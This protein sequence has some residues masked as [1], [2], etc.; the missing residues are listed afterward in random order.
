MS[1]KKALV[2]LAV[3]VLA[4]LVVSVF[5][6]YGKFTDAAKQI[7][8]LK[9]QQTATEEAMTGLTDELAAAQEAQK[10]AEDAAAAAQE[11]QK[12]AEDAAAAAQEAQK[13]AEDKAAKAQEAQKIAEDETAKAVKAQK[14]A[15]DGL[16][17]LQKTSGE[18]IAAAQEAQ[19]NAEDELVKAQKAQKTAEDE[20]AKAQKAVKEDEEQILQLEERIRE[21]ENPQAGEAEERRFTGKNE[22]ISLVVPDGANASDNGT[23]TIQ[24]IFADGGLVVLRRPLFE[25]G[26]AENE[27]TVKWADV[28]TEALNQLLA[29]V[30]VDAADAQA[31]Q[32]T[33]EGKRFTGKSVKLS[34][35]A[36]EGAGANDPGNGMILVIFAN[37]GLVVFSN[38]EDEN[39][40]M[41]KWADV[42]A[43]VLNQLLATVQVNA[44]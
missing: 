8:D 27:M 31:V 3:I 21:L 6:Y 36:P 13:E 35:I 29:T 2:C 10:T 9:N 12:T 43:D 18:E 23:G 17:K 20:L 14:A 25:G 1:K 30:R 32:K 16:A 41:M 4:A 5:V 44:D 22:G 24:V 39:E 42:E 11:A 7:V 37:G 26:D 33:A 38:G 15:E 34:L 19:K 40:I 28:E